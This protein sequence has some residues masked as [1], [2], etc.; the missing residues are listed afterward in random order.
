MSL[1]KDAVAK[2]R[3]QRNVDVILPA[4]TNARLYVVCAETQPGE[5]TFTPAIP[6]RQP[7][8]KNNGYP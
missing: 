2:V 4:F 6:N 1:L 5:L 8:P 7:T 3:A